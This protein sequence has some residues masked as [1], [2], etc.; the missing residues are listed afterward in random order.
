MPCLFG[1]TNRIIRPRIPLN[2]S[3]EEQ[4]FISAATLLRN[5]TPAHAA[6]LQQMEAAVQVGTKDATWP[7]WNQLSVAAKAA[8]V[9]GDPGRAR[10]LLDLG[11]RYAPNDRELQYVS[12]IVNRASR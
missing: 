7:H 6:A 2:A 8:L 12:R 3:P 9:N 10:Q 1:G 4:Q 5:R 11:L